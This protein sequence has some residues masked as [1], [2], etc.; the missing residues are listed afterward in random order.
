M[1]PVEIRN[2][3]KPTIPN[4]PDKNIDLKTANPDCMQQIYLR[5]P[6]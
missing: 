2:Q 6:V 3:T 5:K 1:H 4:T